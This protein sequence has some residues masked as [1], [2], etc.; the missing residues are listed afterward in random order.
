M[1]DVHLFSLFL[2]GLNHPSLAARTQSGAGSSLGVVVVSKVGRN[3]NA[4]W[5]KNCVRNRVKNLRFEAGLLCG[6]VKKRDGFLLN[7]SCACARPETK[8]RRRSK[9]T[10][11][12]TRARALAHAYTR[13]RPLWIACVN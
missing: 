7:Y 1:S 5:F 11:I 4:N 3:K 2:L 10:D 9:H 12:H 8:R 6:P 13:I